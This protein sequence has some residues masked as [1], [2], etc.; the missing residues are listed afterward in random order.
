M[1][2]AWSL[3]LRSSGAQDLGPHFMGIDDSEQ[4]RPTFSRELQKA[5][6]GSDD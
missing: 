5:N 2:K 4:K 3:L 6:S 1:T